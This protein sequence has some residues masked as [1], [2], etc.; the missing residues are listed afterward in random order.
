VTDAP[1]PPARLVLASASAVRSDLLR[2]AGVTFDVLGSGVDE[3]PLKTAWLAEGRDPCRIA[4]GLAKAKARAVA[5]RTPAW[6]IGAD[7]TSEFEGRLGDKPAS[8]AEARHRLKEMRGRSHRLHSAVHLTNGEQSWSQVS[9]AVMHMRTFSDEWLDGYLDRLGSGAL[10]SVGGYQLEGEGVQLFDRVDGD[11][12]AILGL[13]LVPLLA[14]LR[15]FG[16]LLS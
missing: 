11:Y 9:T 14:A 4:A 13:P 7:Q 15:R 3:T 10:E 16:L 5:A 1:A 6:V 8:L 2:R 12:F